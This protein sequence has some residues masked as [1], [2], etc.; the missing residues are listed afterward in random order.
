M[1]ATTTTTTMS[2]R[3]PRRRRRFRVGPLSA[4]RRAPRWCGPGCSRAIGSPMRSSTG[5]P[6][7]ARR[8]GATRSSGSRG[9]AQSRLSDVQWSE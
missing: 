4:A 2:R 3:Q 7:G 6:L 9:R 1:A 8:C 5:C